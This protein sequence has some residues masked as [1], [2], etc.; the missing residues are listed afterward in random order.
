MLP[1][2]D[3]FRTTARHLADHR[4]DARYRAATRAFVGRRA[5]AAGDDRATLFASGLIAGDALMGIGIAGLVVSGAATHL[6][7]RTPGPAGTPLELLLTVAP[8]AA[9]LLVLAAVA[10]PPGR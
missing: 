10:R 6:A 5:D 1:M 7:L 8:F 9:L 4:V 2:I 3:Q